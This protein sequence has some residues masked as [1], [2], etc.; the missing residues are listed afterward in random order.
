M[1]PPALLFC[2][3]SN[4]P[5]GNEVLTRGNISDKNWY[6]QQFYWLNESLNLTMFQYHWNTKLD[7]ID[8]KSVS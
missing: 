6:N 2:A 1:E 5:W 7:K 4:N 8:V 3:N